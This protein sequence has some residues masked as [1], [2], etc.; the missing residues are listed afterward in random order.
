MHRSPLSWIS[1]RHG[2][3]PSRAERISRYEPDFSDP[4]TGTWLMFSPPVTNDTVLVG[5]ARDRPTG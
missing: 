4:S 5:N 2:V 1:T 3:T